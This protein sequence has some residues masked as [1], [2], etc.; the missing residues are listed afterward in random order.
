MTVLDK[1]G[2]QGPETGNR[3][4]VLG[5]GAKQGLEARD[6]HTDGTALRTAKP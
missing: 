3:E 5:M 1:A 2:L 4:P 6:V